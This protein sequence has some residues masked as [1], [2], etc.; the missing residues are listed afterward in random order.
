LRWRKAGPAA[1]VDKGEAPPLQATSNDGEAMARKPSP[2]MSDQAGSEFSSGAADV[3]ALR[4]MSRDERLV[5][6]MKG[7]DATCG[8]VPARRRESARQ[9]PKPRRKD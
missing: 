5:L 8:P 4:S 2:G 6:L 3:A 1:L 7:L 9:E